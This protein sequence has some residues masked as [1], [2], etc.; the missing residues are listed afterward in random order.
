MSPRDVALWADMAGGAPEPIEPEPESLEASSLEAAIIRHL[1]AVPTPLLDPRPTPQLPP[2]MLRVTDGDALDTFEQFDYAM[3]ALL[4]QGVDPE[5]ITICFEP[6][7]AHI[8]GVD[9]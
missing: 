1:D 2:R 8:Y 4:A 3:K 9:S 7:C 5:K 6:G